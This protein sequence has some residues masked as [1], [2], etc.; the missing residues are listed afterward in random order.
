VHAEDRAEMAD[1][2][3]TATAAVW[4]ETSAQVHLLLQ[5]GLTNAGIPFVD[6]LVP[7][8]EAARTGERLYW[9][10]DGHWTPAGHRVCAEYAAHVV[11]AVLR[12]R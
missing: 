6:C 10:W 7:L 1:A 5:N 11:G 8:G 9:Y 2:L 4:E 12:G 3:G